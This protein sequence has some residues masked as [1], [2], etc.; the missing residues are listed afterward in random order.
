MLNDC[1]QLRDIA[2]WRRK[3]PAQAAKLSS[4]IQE[5]LETKIS[6]LQTKFTLISELWTELVPLE[7]RQ[8]C[9]IV[10]I[11]GD[12]LKV[13]VD[14]PSFASELRWYSSSLIEQIKQQ[15]PSARIKDIRYV[16]GRERP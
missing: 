10:G 13:F 16:V 9:R 6:P 1:E 3:H 12:R 4:V 11:S 15:C 8:H 2:K 14:S 7:L 5:L